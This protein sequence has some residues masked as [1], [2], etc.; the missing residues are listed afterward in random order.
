MKTISKNIFMD[1]ALKQATIAF[2]K[3]EIPVGAIIINQEGIIIARA[4]NAV[5]QKQTQTAHAEILAIQ[6]AAK[7]LGGWR[8]N[9]CWI[10][11]TLEPCLMCFSLIQLSRLSGIV[12]GAQST[13]F[14]TSTV[15][16]H[17]IYAKNIIIE[18]GVLKKE[19][20][21]LLTLFFNKLRSQRK[22]YRESK[23]YFF[24]QTQK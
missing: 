1:K 18:G 7:K 15:G 5:E 17:P 14:G 12:F 4:Y 19:C 3:N 24:K 6:R 16:K 13:L 9:G 20:L 10:Y 23:R 22:D 8:L 21:A 2:K 11:V